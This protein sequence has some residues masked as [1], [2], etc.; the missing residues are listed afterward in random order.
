MAVQFPL[1][2]SNRVILD[3]PTMKAILLCYSYFSKPEKMLELFLLRFR[4]NSSAAGVA[5][6]VGKIV[7]LR[8]FS[9]VLK[10]LV[11]FNKD[12]VS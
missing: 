9:G 10:M 2:T 12:E 11:Q 3:T 4:M 7:R 5:E 1:I 6:S 8:V